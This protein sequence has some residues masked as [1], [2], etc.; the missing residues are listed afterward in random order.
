[1]RL[2]THNLFFTILEFEQSDQF[3]HTQCTWIR[4]ITGK[5]HAH[6]YVVSLETHLAILFR[7]I[8][9]L[10]VSSILH[11]SLS[12]FN[13]Q[14]IEFYCVW[15]KSN[16]IKYSVIWL[17]PLNPN[18]NLLSKTI[19][20]QRYIYS[21]LT[22]A[23]GKRKEW[24]RKREQLRCNDRRLRARPCT[25]ARNTKTEQTRFADYSRNRALVLLKAVS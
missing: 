2:A 4:A 13:T 21:N 20:T 6:S 8:K 7:Y 16:R 22:H 18:I 14:K 12:V 1:M 3:E 23:K 19:Y 11:F 24:E 25:F 15:L 17:K 10:F 9:T 5:K